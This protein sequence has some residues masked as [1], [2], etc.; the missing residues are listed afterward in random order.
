MVSRSPNAMLRRAL[1]SVALLS[2]LSAGGW[3]RAVA[4]VRPGTG[5]YPW[6]NAGCAFGAAGG[7]RCANPRNSSDVFD[8][9]VDENHDGQLDG[10][11]GAR[12]MRS[13]ECFDQ[14]GY[15]YRNCTSYVA[16]KLTSLGV[17]RA[18]VSGLGNAAQWP[19]N[20]RRRG[21]VLSA[22]PEEG[23][24]AVDRRAALPFGHLAF[25]ASVHPNGTI[26][27]WEY[28]HPSLSNGFSYGDF[29]TRTGTP[30]ALGFTTFIDFGAHERRPTQEQLRARRPSA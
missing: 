10:G 9:Y 25:V 7:T 20:A 13:G 21:V 15:E 8:W 26:T 5:G 4:T 2:T 11:C 24:V 18:R 19:V 6:A 23:A 14:W 22:V 29:G 12:S 17:P 27:V 1:V 3:A 28:N 16:W 30:A